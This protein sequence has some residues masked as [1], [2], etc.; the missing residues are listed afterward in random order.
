M[1]FLALEEMVKLGVKVVELVQCRVI[2]IARLHILL[3]LSI[4]QILQLFPV[5]LQIVV[6][7][8]EF[9]LACHRLF[10]LISGAENLLQLIDFQCVINSS[11]LDIAITDFCRLVILIAVSLI[12]NFASSYF[13]I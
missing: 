2:Q 1:V 7:R 6:A 13:K 5:G 11:T 4:V 3:R 10:W 12:T 8:V 9:V